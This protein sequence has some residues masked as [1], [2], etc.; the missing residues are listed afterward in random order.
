MST[1]IR[2]ITFLLALVCLTGTVF[3]QSNT[4][5]EELGDESMEKGKYASSVYFYSQVLNRLIGNPDLYYNAYEITAFYKTPKSND[6]IKGL[7]PPSKPTDKQKVLIHK[8]ANSFRMVKDYEN[9]ELWYEAAIKYPNTD[10]DAAE[11]FYGVSLLKNAKVDEAE[12][13]LKKYVETAP[14]KDNP[15]YELAQDKIV[16]CAFMRNPNST[17]QEISMVEPDSILRAGSTNYAVMYHGKQLIFASARFDTVPK[18][19]DLRKKGTSS[20]YNSDLFIADVAE[21]GTVGKPK[22]INGPINVKEFNEGAGVMAPDGRSFFFTRTNPENRSETFIYVSRRFNNSWMEPLKLGDNVNMPGARAMTPYLGEDNTTLY[23]ASNRKDGEG[24]FDIWSTMIDRDGNTT[25]PINLGANINSKADEISP[26]YH[27]V[28][29]TLY[30]SSEGHIGF[31]G[32]DVFKSEIDVNTDW[33]MKAENM[34]KPVNSHRDDSYF[35]LA[36]D[37]TSGYVTSD[38]SEC[39][40]CDSI[41]NLNVNCNK[42]YKLSRPEISVTI[43]GYVFDKQS[44]E[45]I[46]GATVS[47]K[48]ISGENGPIEIETDEDGYYESDLILNMEYFM[49]ARKKKYFRDAGLENTMGLT[50]T[51]ALVHD[52]YLEMIPEGEIEIKGI[53]YDFDSANLREQSKRELDKLLNFLNLNSGISIEI[54]SHTDIRGNDDYNQI[55]SDARAKSVV[56]YLILN[57]INKDRLR[58]KGYGETTPAEVQKEDGTMVS[59]TPE[60]IKSLKTEEE[61]E[62]AHQRNRRTAF[63]VLSQED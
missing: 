35:V 55:L 57:G 20:M 52:F 60:Y 39:E 53:E 14:E 43:S 4:K 33:W 3:A 48:D 17:N 31:G 10:F 25:E 26:F 47:I 50:Q 42:I 37:L 29:K 46:P 34:G 44:E 2:K 8:L 15:Y 36:K 19:K 32:L 58:P 56:D 21:D 30:F 51:T 41:Y 16:S 12:V 40:S 61:Q 45:I 18:K 1:S 5:L 6:T 63:K 27:E 62:E 49:N 28:S 22:K 7:H 9:S 13:V 54:R 23:F 24:G 11:Y 59:L 38:R